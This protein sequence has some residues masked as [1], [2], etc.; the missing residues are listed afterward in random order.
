MFSTRRKTADADHASTV[1]RQAPLSLLLLLLAGVLLLCMVFAVSVGSSSLDMKGSFHI[2]CERIPLIKG[3]VPR[4]E[5]ADNYRTIVFDLRL[6]RIILSLLAGAGLAVVGAVFQSVFRNPLADPHIL[7][8]SSGAAFG[9]TLALILGIGEGMLGLGPIGLFAFMFS[10]LTIWVVYM[11]AG[12]KGGDHA[13]TSMLL[14]GTAVSTLLSSIISLL[15]L[16]N[17]EQ[18]SR[19]YMWTLGSF[20]AANWVKVRFLV[21]VSLPCLAYLVLQGKTLNLLLSGEDEAQSLGLDTAAARKRL[22]FVSGLLVAAIVSVSGIIGFVGLIVPQYLR[23]MRQTDLR[24]QLPLSM[25]CGAVFVL[26]CDTAART[27]LPPVEIPVGIITAI[28]GVPYFIAVLI[29]R[30]RRGLW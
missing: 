2:L 30:K 20:N 1:R 3:L 24:R 10:M 16:F 18:I 4:A 22:I 8:V 12:S 6:P 26:F 15:M 25:L 5:W 7:G 11:A 29:R 17:H 27:L 19:V 14:I 23:I 21:L 13:T 9:A 28:F